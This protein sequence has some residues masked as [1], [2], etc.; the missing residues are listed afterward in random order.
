[1]AWQGAGKRDVSTPEELGVGGMF[2]LHNKPLSAGTHTEILFDVTG[3]EVRA[4]CVVRHSRPDHGM[5][6]QFVHMAGEDRARLHR[7]VKQLEEEQ[8]AQAPPPLDWFTRRNFALDSGEVKTHHELFALLNR[9]YSTRMTGQLQ[10]VLG[11]VERQLFFDG[12]QLVFATSSDR[13]DSLGEMMLREGAL[14]Q[15][16]F[17]EASELLK[18][19]QRFGS[20]L[21]ELGVRTVDEITVWV[22][23]QLMQI[24]S[25]V[26]DYPACRFYFFSSL[27]KNVVPEIAIPVPLGKLLLEAIRRANDLPL[28]HLAADTDLRITLSPD[29]L[30]RYQA[31]DLNR[32]ERKL[33]ASITQPTRVKELLAG[34][35]LDPAVAARTLYSLLVLGEVVNANLLTMEQPATLTQ[36]QPAQVQ[37]TPQSENRAERAAPDAAPV[38][39][40]APSSPV[41]TE[42]AAAASE[43]IAPKPVPEPASGASAESQSVGE[44]AGANNF[45]EEVR[46]LLASAQKSTY[47]EMLGV[48]A[49]SSVEQVKENFHRMARKFH[50]DR[51]MGHSERLELLQDLMGRLTIAYKTLTNEERRAAY[52]KQIASA[53]AF[54]LGQQEKTEELETVEEC[55]T[56]AKQA[57]RAMNFAGSLLWLRKCVEIAPNVAKHHAMLARSLAAFP[58]YRQ[59]AVRHFTLAIELD[60]WNT[61]TYFQFGELY[62]T[63]GLPW[64]AVPLYRRLL[65]IDPEHTKA[66]DRLAA[67][68]TKPRRSGK[69]FLSRM[70]HRDA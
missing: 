53:G 35:G 7:F 46:A 64:R 4:R 28:E 66:L 5:G 13:Y 21:A 67:L 57:L 19:G 18:T 60:Q 27:D 30:L 9:I 52:D 68:E 11:R 54:T 25:S 70:L 42:S 33:L 41:E 15:A 45:E 43:P 3:G 58:Q 69:S 48:T 12:G 40:A 32:D 47:Y 8:K 38:A 44:S 29:P 14:T 17:E 51:H 34:S 26:L 62:E 31:V 50:P 1:M 37:P 16:Q 2:L 63:M 55:L 59:D 20:A 65:E 23:R 6:L 56:R 61:S 36:H 49:E 10:L 24:T 22:Q 39:A